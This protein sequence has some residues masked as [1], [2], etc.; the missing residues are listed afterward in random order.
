MAYIKNIVVYPPR[1]ADFTGQVQSLFESTEGF[2]DFYIKT[3]D[4]DHK[5][6][7]KHALVTYATVEECRKAYE[8]YTQMRISNTRIFADPP[9]S[10]RFSFSSLIWKHVKSRLPESTKFLYS[11]SGDASIRI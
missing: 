9:F 2:V 7:K 10:K 11:E 3:T 8:R 4:P 6:M 1:I 5:Y